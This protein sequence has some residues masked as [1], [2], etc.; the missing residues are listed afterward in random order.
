MIYHPI[1]NSIMFVV[2]FRGKKNVSGVNFGDKST[3]STEN[4]KFMFRVFPQN[5][6]SLRVVL[7]WGYIFKNYIAA[8]F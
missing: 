1:S 3:P 5:C 4:E 6:E 7:Q 8:L 2:T